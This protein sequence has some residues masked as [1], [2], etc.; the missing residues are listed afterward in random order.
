MG[1]ALARDILLH[2]VFGGAIERATLDVDIRV[3]LRKWD[4]FKSCGCG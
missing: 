4:E 2:H 1:G 3:D